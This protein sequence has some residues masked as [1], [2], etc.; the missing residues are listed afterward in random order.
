MNTIH[1]VNLRFM[2]QVNRMMKS[3]TVNRSKHKRLPEN[4]KNGLIIEI[5]QAGFQGNYHGLRTI[6]HI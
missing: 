3:I 4:F 5:D 6:R 1:Q 2:M